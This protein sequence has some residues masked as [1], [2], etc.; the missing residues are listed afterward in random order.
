MN[1]RALARTPRKRK[2]ELECSTT[3]LSA[4]FDKTAPMDIVHV[5]DDDTDVARK[6][7]KTDFITPH[8]KGGP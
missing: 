4:T 8:N 3:S 1:N 7:R 5:E 6:T 2:R